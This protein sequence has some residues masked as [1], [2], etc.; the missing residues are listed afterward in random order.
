MDEIRLIAYLGNPGFE[1]ARTRHN[2]GWMLA[3]AGFGKQADWH[4]RFKGLY[5][6]LQSEG[7][8]IHLLKPQT[9]MNRSGDSVCA[10]MNFLKLT[11]ETLLVVHDEIELPFGEAGFKFS[12]GL[13]GHNGL[14]SV[15][16]CLGTRDFYRFRLGVSRPDH[17]DV[18]SYVLSAFSG[19]EK[20][21]L[22]PL[23]EQSARILSDGLEMGM[24]EAVVKLKKIRIAF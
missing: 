3:D 24:E 5:A 10:A 2:A 17:K 1:Y 6:S 23:F 13:G 19:E 21:L 7:K 18:A 22:H 11:P 20:P 4:S 16:S 12:G 9:F 15:A 14:R 8:K